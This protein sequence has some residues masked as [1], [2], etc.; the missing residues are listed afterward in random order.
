[1]FLLG[2]TSVAGAYVIQWGFASKYF[3]VLLAVT[4]LAIMGGLFPENVRPM[5]G[6]VTP[7]ALTFGGLSAI[8]SYNLQK[9]PLS[10][11]SVLLGA[12]SLALSVLFYPYMGLPRESLTSYLGLGEGTMERLIICPIL[13][14]IIGFGSHLIGFSD[15]D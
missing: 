11:I 2:V 5:H 12:L 4:G 13:L 14:W 1:M 6:V 15:Q 7:I 8:A 9:P 3:F 10:Y